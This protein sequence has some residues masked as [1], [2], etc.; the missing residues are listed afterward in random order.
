MPTW[1]FIERDLSH[2][3]SDGGK[4]RFILGGSDE[5]ID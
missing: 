3:M 1:N 4:L 5:R 2:L